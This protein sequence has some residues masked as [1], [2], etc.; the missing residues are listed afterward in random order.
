MSNNNKIFKNL[1][2]QIQILLDKGLII[3]DV[4]FSI[5]SNRVNNKEKRICLPTDM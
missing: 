5:L 4:D 2:E 1:D 3:N